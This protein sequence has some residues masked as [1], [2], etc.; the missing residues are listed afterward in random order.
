MQ[1]GIESPTLHVEGTA[2]DSRIELLAVGFD[3]GVRQPDRL[4]ST[5]ILHSPS[6]V[7]TT[8]PKVSVKAWEVQSA[9]MACWWAS[10]PP[11]IGPIGN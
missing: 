4:R 7:S 3:E 10:S 5:L 1:S 11:A 6:H 2:Y 8:T 9:P